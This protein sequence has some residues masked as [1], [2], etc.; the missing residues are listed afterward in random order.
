MGDNLDNKRIRCEDCHSG[1][2]LLVPTGC[3][4]I[5]KAHWPGYTAHTSRCR[6]MGQNDLYS[7]PRYLQPSVD[8]G[9]E[10]SIAEVRNHRKYHQ[11]AP[12]CEDQVRTHS[13]N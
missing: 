9:F 11:D 12:S 10:V 6:N 5:Q 13:G 7:H 1:R 3:E 2:W 8:I 4:D